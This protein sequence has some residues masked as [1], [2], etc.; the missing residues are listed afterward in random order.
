MPSYG[1]SFELASD[2]TY[3][4]RYQSLMRQIDISK[5]NPAWDETTSFALVQTSE[6]LDAF[7]T[8]LYINTLV[9]SATD[10]LL[11]FDPATSS[12]IARGPIKYPNLLKSH[13]RYCVLK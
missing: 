8:R 1:V 3:R 2:S 5:A 11:V 10:I 13:F 9:S 7:A 12:A 6:S 4:D